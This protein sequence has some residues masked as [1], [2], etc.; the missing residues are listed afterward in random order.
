MHVLL[1]NDDGFDAEGLLALRRELVA[2]GVKVSVIAPDGNRSGIGRALTLYR[3]VRVEQAGGDAGS[4]VYACDGNP[5]DCVRIG[6]L[7][8]L[9]SPVDVVVAGINHGSNLGDDSTYSGTLG[10]ALEGALLGLPAAGFSQEVIGG[11]HRIDG[12]RRHAEFPF[13]AVAA[14]ITAALADDPTPPGSAL[15]VNFPVRAG[16]TELRLTRPARRRYPRGFLAPIAGEPETAFHPYGRPT[17]V[18]SPYEDD[19]ETDVAAVDADC[20]SVSIVSAV[21]AHEPGEP[22]RGWLASLAERTADMAG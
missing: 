4:P 15:S 19:P 6:L 8:E 11:G 13:A 21:W 16:Q 12:V 22:H 1:T 5:V 20:I 3:P 18:S 2:L 14:R 7:S 17:D 10:A 9:L